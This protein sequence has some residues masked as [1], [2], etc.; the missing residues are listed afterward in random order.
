[1]IL[2]IDAPRFRQGCL[3]IIAFLTLLQPV[4]PAP[5]V[6]KKARAVYAPRPQLPEIARARRPRG[7]GYFQFHIRPDG[8]VWRVDVL[9][10]TGHKILDDTTVAA[11]SR[12]RFQPGTRSEVRIP[13]TYTGNYDSR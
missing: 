12:W 2:L 4:Y 9:R 6:Q 5:S 13:F 7:D 8:S 10:S 3:A 11:L 1:M